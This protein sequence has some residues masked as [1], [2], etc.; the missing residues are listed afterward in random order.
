V[1]SLKIIL[2]VCFLILLSIFLL[3]SIK[4]DNGNLAVTGPNTTT[5]KPTPTV[6]PVL[7][8][9]AD[10]SYVGPKET[11]NIIIKAMK[12]STLTKPSVNSLVSC[13]VSG[14]FLIKDTVFTDSN[15]RAIVRFTDSASAQITLTATC[16]ND[17]Q[18]FAFTV[19]NSPDKI[20]QSI[21]IIP[22]KTVLKADGMDTT[23]INVTLRNANNNPIGAGECVKFITT[24]GTIAG[25][26]GS[27]N[28][29]GESP[30]NAQGLA[31]AT[32][33]SENKNDT[34]YVTAFLASDLTK[35][36]ET[37][38]VF[39]GVTINLA[40][41]STNLKVG[42]Q[43]T[44]TATLINASNA[45]IPYVPIYFLRG[46]DTA[47]NLSIVAR[48]TA[49]N[50]LGKATFV[51]MGKKIGTDS[52]R[53]V[54]AGAG[55]S[56]R[57]TVTN[58]SLSLHLSDQVL[59]A[60]FSDST[61]LSVVLLDNNNN[62]IS[63][64]IKITRF[65][66]KSDGTDTS[67][68]NIITTNTQG[69]A[70]F[71]VYALPY[72]D[73]M[74]IEA[75]AFDSSGDLASA[76]TTVSFITTRTMTIYAIP[77]VIQADGTSKSQITV[78]I[79]NSQNNP[80]VGDAIQFT[81]DAGMVTALDTA[82]VNGIATAFL[83]SD[84]RNTIATVTGTL[85][86]DP[87][88]T[89]TVQVEFS[90]VNITATAIPQSINS[91]GKDTSIVTLTLLDAANNPIVGEQVNFNQKHPDVTHLSNLDSV[92]NNRG[93]ASC[94][95]SGTGTGFDTISVK[96]AGASSSVV[97]SYSSN[98]LAA[99]TA[100]WQPCIA[101]GNDS[102]QI[103][104]RYFQGDKITPIQNATINVS[105]TV[106]SISSAP[107]FAK[108]FTLAPSNLGKLLFYM[109]NPNFSTTATI[110]VQ[111]QTTQEITSTTYQLYFSASK[112]KRIVLTGSPQVI[113]VNS[114]GSTA[115]MAKITG[116]AYDSMNNLVKG[117]MVGFNMIHGPGSGEYLNPPTAQTGSDGSVTTYLVAG[118]TPSMFN[119]VWVVAG[120]LSANK[121]DTVKFTI[122]GPPY[123]I[124]IRTSL[125]EGIDYKDGTFGL[126]CAA[127]V[128]DVNGNPVA[129]GTAIT[130]S[131][132]VSGYVNKQLSAN[133]LWSGQAN[134]YGAYT[135]TIDTTYVVL[136]FEDFNNNFKCDPGED[137]NGDGV[138]SRGEDID[139][140]GQ[141]ITGPA[142]LDI[143]H[144]GKR[145]YLP[146]D[147]VE[148][149]KIYPVGQDAAGNT[150]F[151]TAFADYVGD[152]RLY[153]KEPMIG[154]DANMSDSEYTALL[155]AYKSQHHNM[156]YD[157]D[158]Y[159]QNGVVDPNTAVS[160]T[161]T[162]QTISGKATNTILYGQSDATRVEIMV[163][164]EC[165]GIKTQ[166]P[167]QL[168]LPIIVSK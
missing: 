111:A 54:A 28:D 163:W 114:S 146:G 78:Q 141:F 33:T 49:T 135:V 36:I 30:T 55:A 79:K 60:R 3:C 81:S 37:K 158:S 137:R 29:P 82:N 97:I 1:K 103:R 23:T 84:R 113:S 165:Q 24:S 13:S 89:V 124:T 9:S 50:Y 7:I 42:G 126:P 62:G 119:D 147:V 71:T 25:T 108:Q 132:Q 107:V 106:G 6:P 156:G 56:A 35:S 155:N 48:D 53:V 34:A 101:N 149:Y 8:I 110:S 11:L 22:A 66:Q 127:L 18:K 27:C 160:I 122:A 162:G 14:G 45:P 83:T 92:T 134:G 130:F 72:E 166:S 90:G 73:N 21:R 145:D 59:Q 168:V 47:S 142:Y 65:F 68:L 157:F 46:K 77:T 76:V 123:S 161:R 2:A 98:F 10:S 88:K 20:Q 15:G 94:R 80:I 139:G 16:Y 63:K 136:P 159:P 86:R 67:A 115:N 118:T 19:T 154:A 143:N 85:V 52:I 95:V 131:L 96:S 75:V 39:Q 26:N 74:N 44:I 93:Q 38:V 144:N 151:D 104:I 61:V 43:A 99:D 69:K 129:D 12:D 138:A 112:I 5:T 31:Q 120:D 125:T 164:A 105:V 41:D 117:Q 32:L 167:A 128:T 57:I 133:F 64:S 87:T 4:N 102:T 148:P 121:S 51:V 58:L 116:I 140:D 70:S 109:K 91:S 100:F 40:V 153:T 152:G 150:I 17:T